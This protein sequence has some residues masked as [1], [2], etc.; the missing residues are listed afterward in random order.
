[1]KKLSDLHQMK[2]AGNKISMVT[3]YDYPSAKQVEAAGIDMILVGDSLGM[4]V[5][6]YDST[7]DVTLDDMLHHS[8]AVRRGAPDTFVVVDMPF[9]MVGVD[10]AT[11]LQ[12][13]AKLY[14][15]S[16]ANAVKVEGGHLTSFIQQATYLGIPV[17]AHLGLTPQSVGVMGYRMQGATKAGAERL[18]EDSKAVE[19]AGA[20]ALVLEAVPSDLAEHIS[21]QLDIP[22]IG[23]GAGKGTDGQ[24]LVYHDMLNYG[25]ERTAKFVKQYGDFSTGVAALKQYDDEVKSSA[26]PS[27]QY[28]YQKQ[29]MDEVEK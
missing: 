8:K 25:V 1:M 19:K 21:G 22:V 14:Q 27:E 17:V 4:T 18:I 29:I 5:L 13:A 24:V 26:F 7:V 2:Q 23:I 15:Q 9:G 6:G 10:L 16:G 12:N 28:T 20:V 11:D 3:A